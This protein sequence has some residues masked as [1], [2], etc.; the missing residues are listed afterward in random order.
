MKA[1]L[2]IGV[3]GILIGLILMWTGQRMCRTTCWIDDAFKLLLPAA[4]ESW[5]GGLPVVLIGAGFIGHAIYKRPRR[6]G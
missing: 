4:Y 6:S 5:A 1:E 3:A 2:G